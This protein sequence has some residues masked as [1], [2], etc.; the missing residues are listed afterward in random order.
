MDVR[1]RVARSNCFRAVIEKTRLP[2]AARRWGLL[3]ALGVVLAFY[4][5]PLTAQESTPP[6]QDRPSSEVHVEYTRL[7][8][9]GETLAKSGDHAGALEQYSRALALGPPNRH[10]E[11][12]L[13]T[14]RAGALSRLGRDS[15]ALRDHDRAVSLD[16]SAF[17]LWAR[18]ETLRKVG[19]FADALTEYDAVLKLAPDDAPAHV[20]RATALWRLGRADQAK[21]G[22]DRAVAIKP[23]V[24]SLTHRAFFLT[25]QRDLQGAIADF[26]KVIEL[27]P[28]HVAARVNR[29]QAHAERGEFDRALAD[30]EAALRLNAN[31][32]TV[33][34]GRGW[35]YERQGSI[36]RARADYR[37]GLELAPNDAW[38][39]RAITNLPPP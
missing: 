11:S 19:R 37:R 7:V 4:V 10:A 17:A 38:L 20:G 36:D 8:R 28:T 29:A 34:R 2:S 25:A 23:D 22:Y 32:A 16:R 21:G 14:Y 39:R 6:S 15:E 1:L 31:D 18:G 27:D 13:L 3:V 30:Y 35:V 9:A 26:G 12:V 5:S 33:Y 24:H